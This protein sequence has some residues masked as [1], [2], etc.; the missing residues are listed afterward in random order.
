[1]ARANGITHTLTVPAGA[2]DGGFPGQGSLIHLD[3]WTVEEMDI[4]PGAAFVMTWPSLQQRRFGFGGFGGPA[5]ERSFD[6]V[7][8]EYE[9]AVDR[10][11]RWLETARDYERAVAAGEDIPRD[12]RLEALARVADGEA[13]VLAMVDDERD[14]RNVVAY[15]QEQ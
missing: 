12:L 4:V 7:R 3:G 8:E 1:V 15:A 14:I 5:R 6:Q 10:I 11:T 13:P 2:D 9:R